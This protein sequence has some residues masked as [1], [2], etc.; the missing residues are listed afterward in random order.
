MVRAWSFAP[1]LI[2]CYVKLIQMGLIALPV[3]KVLQTFIVE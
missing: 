2:Y 1:E 3:L